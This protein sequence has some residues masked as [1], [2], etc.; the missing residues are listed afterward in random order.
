MSFQEL[1]NQMICDNNN[2]NNNDNDKHC[3]I[4]YELLE[5]KPIVLDCNHKF[6]YKYIF[7]EIKKQKLKQNFREIQRLKKWQIKCPYCRTVQN[8]LLPP[9]EGFPKILW[10][11]HPLKYVK[12]P[13]KCC[14]VFSSGKRKNL[15]CN[16]P[17]LHKCC[18]AHQKIL[19]KRAT[20]IL[21]EKKPSKKSETIFCS[22]VTK[23]GL[24]C[25]RKRNILFATPFCCQHANSHKKTPQNSIINNNIVTI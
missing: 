13:F 8:F 9:K 4:S 17:S 22:A 12:M 7:Q 10:V 1:L 11:N 18:N 25:K 20:K 5:N 3:L 6:N 23:K 15:P 14:Y 24:R 2:N 19:A 16:K 21:L